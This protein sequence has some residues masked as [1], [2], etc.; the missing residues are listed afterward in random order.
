LRGLR[1]AAAMAEIVGD[2]Q[3]ALRLAA[4]RDAFGAT[5]RASIAA[6]LAERDIAYIPGSVELADFDPTA[7][8]NAVALIEELP[9]WFESAIGH[10]FDRYVSGFRERFIEN[11]NW[12]NYSPYE[13]RTVAALVRLDRRQEAHEVLKFFL[14]DR[15]PPP[16]NQWAEIAWRDPQSPAH[17]GDM[18]HT[19]IGAEYILALRTLFAFEREATQSLV[20]AAGICDEWLAD[21]FEIVVKDLPTYDG[22]LCYTLRRDHTDALHFSLSGDLAV[23]PGKIIVKPP[24]SHPIARVEGGGVTSFDAASV[25][26][27]QCPVDLIIR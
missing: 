9:A 27:E 7:T 25:T 26:I 19:W 2:E 6:T 5:L 17:I 15:R 4:L 23:P 3:Q 12:T 22:R 10:T 24:L 18:P 14:A 11:N 16:W 8:A 13:I 21:D 1:D 20:L